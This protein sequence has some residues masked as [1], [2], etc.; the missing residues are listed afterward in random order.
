MPPSELE[1]IKRKLIPGQRIVRGLNLSRDNAP[2]EEELT[3]FIVRRRIISA[4]V[5]VAS[6]RELIRIVYYFPGAIDEGRAQVLHEELVQS[7]EGAMA[8]D[9]ISTARLFYTRP[10]LGDHSAEIGLGEVLEWLVLQHPQTTCGDGSPAHIE[11][12]AFEILREGTE[13]VPQYLMEIVAE[14]RYARLN[15]C[16]LPRPADDP[17]FSEKGRFVQMIDLYWSLC[18]KVIVYQLGAKTYD[19]DAITLLVNKLRERMEAYLAELGSFDGVA[20]AQ[21]AMSALMETCTSPDWR[22]LQTAPDRT[23]GMINRID[24]FVKSANI[25]LRRREYLLIPEERVFI[26]QANDELDKFHAFLDEKGK[27]MSTKEETA[28]RRVNRE[29]DATPALRAED[30]PKDKVVIE[31]K[32]VGERVH[33]LVN[34][35]D[36]GAFPFPPRLFVDSMLEAL[37]IEAIERQLAGKIKKTEKKKPRKRALRAAAIDA[38]KQVLREHLRAARDHAHNSVR[39]GSG[40]ALLPRPTQKQLAAQLGISESSVSRAINDPSDK[41]ITILWEGAKDLEQVMNFKG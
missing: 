13:L 6:L 19:P 40:A 30:L 23:R 15:R 26:R 41:E 9:D 39:C 38:I 7:L 12:A 1:K 36:K 25:T 33:W 32:E 14:F 20:E 5:C 18:K 2:T 31:R 22:D 28:G 4:I 21:A 8:H 34:G 24:T 3:K 35:V 37:D 16:R 27:V 17:S 10:K 11:K 29:T